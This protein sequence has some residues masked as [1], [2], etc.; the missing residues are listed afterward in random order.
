MEFINKKNGTN[1]YIPSEIYNQIWR[2]AFK[3]T[4]RINM[5]KVLLE[6]NEKIEK[7]NSFYTTLNNLYK[8]GYEN[9]L[10]KQWSLIKKFKFMK[11]YRNNLKNINYSPYVY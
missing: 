1:L 2:F 6:L 4:E 8:I 3:T 10:W 7:L 11:M 9:L 5:D